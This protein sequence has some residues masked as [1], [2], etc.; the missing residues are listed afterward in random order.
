MTTAPAAPAAATEERVSIS[1]PVSI[2]GTATIELTA[3]EVKAIV[4]DQ[5]PA[6]ER[7]SYDD[8]VEVGIS[9]WVDNTL[10]EA[11]CEAIYPPDAESLSV[12][13]ADASCEVGFGDIEVETEYA[14]LSGLWKTTKTARISLAK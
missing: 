5:I 2:S 1:V 6:D 12:D 8:L 14:D 11:V 4:E 3:S 13:G 10:A 9:A 7:D